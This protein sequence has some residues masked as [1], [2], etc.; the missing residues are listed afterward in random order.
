MP[1]LAPAPIRPPGLPVCRIVALC[2]QFL[3]RLVNPGVICRKQELIERRRCRTPKFAHDHVFPLGWDRR[4]LGVYSY[5][6]YSGSGVRDVVEFGINA[7][8]LC[9]VSM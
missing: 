7:G 2:D 4:V 1:R 8:V 9:A 6:I 5:K 3:P